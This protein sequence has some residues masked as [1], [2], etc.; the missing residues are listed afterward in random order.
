MACVAD[1]GPLAG[2]KVLEMC[3]VVSG[4]F[5]TALLADQGATVIKVENPD[6]IGDLI[7]VGMPNA[8]SVKGMNALFANVNRGKKSV[9]LNARTEDGC[10]A[11]KNL[12]K[13]A[14][15]LIQN[16]RPGAAERMGLGYADLK[17]QNED[18][19]YVSLTG[20][21]DSGPYSQH[22]HLECTIQG[23][24][25]V[26][27]HAKSAE[28]GPSL[29]PNL[30]SDK[31]ASLTVAQAVTSAL[32]ARSQG[33][34]GQCVKLSMLECSMQFL[35]PD[36]Y[37]NH[38][39]LHDEAGQAPPFTAAFGLTKTADGEVCSMKLG[40]LASY[41][42]TFKVIC[43]CLEPTSG[44][45][46]EAGNY[47]DGA[48][49][50]ENMAELVGEIE[51]AF[52]K[53]STDEVMRDLDELAQISALSRVNTVQDALSDPQIKH[54]DCIQEVD[55]GDLGTLRQAKHAA[56]FTGTPIAGVKRP[57]S[58]GEHTDEVLKN[59]LGYDG[60]RIQRMRER[61]VMGPEESVY[62]VVSRGGTAAEIGLYRAKAGMERCARLQ[63]RQKTEAVVQDIVEQILDKVDKC[64]Q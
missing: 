5:A 33:R 30:V 41:P 26:T 22:Q 55:C 16:F 27:H 32:F 10:E 38:T 54:I 4:P 63:K 29:L 44:A 37:S 11:V 24:T 3:N 31:V 40:I 6:G 46:S 59:I 28:D 58:Y 56:S 9:V 17:A 53:R 12:V 49:R 64:A 1:Q 21:G 15:V 52:R 57:P 14:D 47:K 35:W 50:A 18:L 42:P 13:W 45:W 7:R 25:G 19:I 20:V 2:V 62:D 60:E 39:F 23:I 36:V 51:A 61:G 48:R 8:A 43:D 34:G